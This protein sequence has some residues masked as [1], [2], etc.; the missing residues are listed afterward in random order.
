MAADCSHFQW[1]DCISALAIS[2]QLILEIAH[3]T[4]MLPGGTTTI[5][6]TSIRLHTMHFHGQHCSCDDE[7]VSSAIGSLNGV[8]IASDN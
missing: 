5:H 8:C 4:I 2:A 1:C 6:Q 7:F 3:T